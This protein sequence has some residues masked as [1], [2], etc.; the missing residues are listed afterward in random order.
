MRVAIARLVASGLVESDAR[1]AYRLS[2]RAAAIGAHVE[3]WRRGERRMKAW[4]GQW[5]AVFLPRAPRRADRARSVRTLAFLGF[6]EGLE[7]LWVRPHNLAE[8]QT[9]TF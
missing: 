4:N 9:E 1:G 6:R 7:R 5:L 2:A 3:G 8:P